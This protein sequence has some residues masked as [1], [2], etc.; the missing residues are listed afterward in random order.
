MENGVP[1]DVPFLLCCCNARLR[2]YTGRLRIPFRPL[3]EPMTT[4]V[5]VTAQFDVLYLRQDLPRT[6]YSTLQSAVYGR[7]YPMLRKSTVKLF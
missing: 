7:K 3:Q 5:D 2:D 1:D 4:S 6:F